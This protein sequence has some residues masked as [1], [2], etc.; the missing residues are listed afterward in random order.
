MLSESDSTTRTAASKPAKP[1]KRNLAVRCLQSS[2]RQYVIRIASPAK[3]FHAEF[4][5]ALKIC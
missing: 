4:A 3:A 5:S 1:N 2:N